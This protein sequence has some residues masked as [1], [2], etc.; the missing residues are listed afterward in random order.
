MESALEMGKPKVII[1]AIFKK[2]KRIFKGEMFKIVEADSK[3][4][5]QRDFRVNK[6]L[7]LDL[8]SKVEHQRDLNENDKNILGKNWIT[9]KKCIT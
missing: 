3:N 6:Y 1:E 2:E 5:L 9:E 8:L 4:E 7:L